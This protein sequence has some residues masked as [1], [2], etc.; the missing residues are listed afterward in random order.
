MKGWS[1]KLC[2]Q[3]GERTWKDLALAKDGQLSGL[4]KIGGL[5]PV[6]VDSTGK[7]SILKLHLVRPL[8]L[9]TLKNEGNFLAEQVEYGKA[10][11]TTL[12]NRVDYARCGIE[13]VRKVLLQPVFPPR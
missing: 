11:E 7:I 13:R 10:N 9:D 1:A 5:D 3:P 4:Y 12:R 8:A 2:P 6:K